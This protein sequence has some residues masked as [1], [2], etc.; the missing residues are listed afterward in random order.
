MAREFPD[1]E[2]RS[3]K[4]PEWG[5]PH[6]WRH[7]GLHVKCLLLLPDLE[8]NGNV[9]TNFSKT[10]QY[11]ISYK[12]VRP[13]SSCYMRSDGWSYFNW[14]CAE[15]Q[16]QLI[17]TYCE[18]VLDD[19]RVCWRLLRF[20]TRAED[21]SCSGLRGTVTALLFV[22][23]CA[24]KCGTWVVS[25]AACNVLSN[26]QSERPR[27]HRTTFLH[28]LRSLLFIFDFQTGGQGQCTADI[29]NYTRCHTV[30]W[31]VTRHSVL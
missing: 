9:N 15:M 6:P 12:C 17:R 26:R 8:Q 23:R 25:A 14:R 19:A 10:S 3:R 5:I 28:Q 20:G 29:G 1:C 22:S 21:R 18:R 7:V 11:Q 13:L 16:T 31:S 30:N 2:F 24:K 27:P 4:F